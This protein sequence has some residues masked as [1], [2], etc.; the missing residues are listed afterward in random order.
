MAASLAFG[1]ESTVNLESILLDSFDGDSPYE[2]RVVGSKFATTTDTD[3]FPRAQLISAWPMAIFG[4]NRENKELKSLGIWSRF[5][6]RGY[7]W[8]DV[9]PVA[10]DG[11]DDAGPAEIPIPGR[12][13]SL[14]LWIWGSNLNYYV[15][16]YLR[17]YQG[18]VHVLNLGS[19][20]HSGWKNHRVT[21]GNS[22]P[23]AK[24]ILPRLAA[25]S[26]VKFRIWTL[27]A[28][29]VGDAYIYFDQ[30]KVLTDTF[31]AIFDGD[32]LARP[33]TVQELWNGG[34]DGSQN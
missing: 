2:W 13:R 28:E 32:E 12:A 29:Q 27:P 19:I 6:R 26:F 11:G 1:D 7:N 23:Q 30:L 8:V 15:E 16:I 17:D 9:Y 3:A 31:E 14:D 5:D 4:T 20:A 33:E 22:I 10:K 21:V 34:S 18:V 25:L 24:R